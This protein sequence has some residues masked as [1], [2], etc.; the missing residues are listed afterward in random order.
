MIGYFT[1]DTN[2]QVTSSNKDSTIVQ[3]SC[4]LSA[5]LPVPGIVGCKVCE[6]E[7]E[8]NCYT[9]INSSNQMTIGGQATF[10]SVNNG[11]DDDQLVRTYYV[12]AVDESSAQLDDCVYAQTTY[13]GSGTSGK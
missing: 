5:L 7:G 6:G 11:D 1:E 10:T 8:S 4:Q 13:N 2:L 12:Y 9:F 3:V